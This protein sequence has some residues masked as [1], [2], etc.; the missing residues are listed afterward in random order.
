VSNPIITLLRSPDSSL[1]DSADQ[2]NPANMELGRTSWILS[3][4]L[5][6]ISLVL[7]VL[8]G[9]AR[10][11]DTLRAVITVAPV[12][13]ASVRVEL[14]SSTPNYLWS[15]RN[16]YGAAIGLGER[17]ESFAG[18]AANGQGI[19]VQKLAP[20]EFRTAEKVKHVTYDVALTEPS[21]PADM[22]HVS[23]LNGERGLLM[24]ADLLPQL[25]NGTAASAAIE[26]RMP[27]GWKVSS[28]VKNSD[29]AFIAKQ[30]DKAVFLVATSLIAHR[31]RIDSTELL[32][33]MSGDWPIS[34]GDVAKLASKMIEEYSKL[35][36]FKLREDAVVTLLPFPGQAGAERWTAETRGNNLVLLLGPNAGRGQLLARLGVIFT[37]EVFHFWVPNSL[38]LRGDYDWFFEGFTLYQALRTALGLGLID[39]R[40]YLATLARVYD[41]YLLAADRDR[42]SLIE[43]SERRW[44]SSSPLVY[45]KGM[46]VAFIYDLQLKLTSGGKAQFGDTY[47]ELFRSDFSEARDANEVIISILD[48]PNGMNQFSAQFI[49]TA[50]P[51][52]LAPLLAA[53]GIRVERTDF[54]THLN[55]A[56]D[57][58]DSQR[59]LLRSLGY[60]K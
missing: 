7:F 29:G 30:P 21:R 24:M 25:Q 3:T 55:I 15:F 20:G 39:S 16:T 48:H 53:Y 32:V 40:E 11:Q 45:D 46:L 22:S 43:L 9:L 28:N 36:G 14:E 10:A 23:W 1:L 26:I 41:S 6:L 5:F 8:P 35:T 2:I 60:K 50:S 52:S 44:T 13:P 47:R 33:A 56:K 49:K 19:N 57:A 59:R 58:N 17:V 34:G 42:F 38:S 27:D 51:I 37:H 12:S 54:Q 4:K 31:K 18:I